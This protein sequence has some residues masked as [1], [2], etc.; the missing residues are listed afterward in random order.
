MSLMVFYSIFS[1]KSIH[2]LLR[3]NC[4]SQKKVLEQSEYRLDYEIRANYNSQPDETVEKHSAGISSF[5]ATATG[6][7]IANA[8]DNN[9][10]NCKNRTYANKKICNSLNHSNDLSFI[11]PYVGQC[12][13]HRIRDHGKKYHQ[14][15]HDYR[16][17][18]FHCL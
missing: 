7:D 2:G 1:K 15:D 10:E 18:L 6:K 17:P 9:P 14:R 13:R 3:S 8:C 12:L 11:K 16:S 4:T 5:F